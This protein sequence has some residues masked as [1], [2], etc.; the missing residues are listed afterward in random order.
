MLKLT[1]ENGNRL[2]FVWSSYMVWREASSGVAARRGHVSIVPLTGSVEQGPDD[3]PQ[4]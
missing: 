2:A 1:G 4:G 3:E